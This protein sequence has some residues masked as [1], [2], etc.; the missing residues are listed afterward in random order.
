MPVTPTLSVQVST[1]PSQNPP[2]HVAGGSANEDPERNLKITG[3]LR[4]WRGGDEAALAR[5]MAVTYRELKQIA[6]HLMD[7]ERLS[8]TL[9][10]TALV[11]EAYLRLADLDRIEWRDRIHFYAMSARVMRRVLV[12]H[13]RSRGRE[14][15]GSGKRVRLPTAALNQAAAVEAPDI[16]A[17][18]DALRDLAS[19]D[20]ERATV[21]E[22]RYFGGLERSEI[23]EYLGVSETTV[24]RRW[25][26]ARAFLIQYLGRAHA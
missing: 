17:L 22:L 20:T 8:H 14:K 16:L 2:A 10:P 7:R 3:L 24:T 9:Q 21:I 23:A 6:A 11:H 25:R 5:L 12:D 1:G 15:R 13:A 4:A 18:D 19:R 26:S